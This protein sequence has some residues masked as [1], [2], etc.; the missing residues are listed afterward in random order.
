MANRSYLYSSN[1]IPGEDSTDVPTLTGLSEWNYDIPLVYRIL[2]SAAPRLCRSSIWEMDEPIALIAD[3][4]QGVERLRAF[5]EPLAT[6]QTRERIQEAFDFLDAPASRNRYL[7]LECGEIFDMGSEPLLEQNRELLERLLHLDPAAELRQLAAERNPATNDIP[8]VSW[9][10]R[11]FGRKQP[12]Q[13]SLSQ[14]LERQIDH[15]GLG[16][17]SNLLYFDLSSKD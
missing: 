3:Y 16:N 17:W 8:Q 7:V 2:L 10:A 14:L 12:A 1:I 4:Q 9:F 15:I 13:P 5:L 6:P 11:L